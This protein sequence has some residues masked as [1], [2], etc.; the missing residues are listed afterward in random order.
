MEIDLE[1]NFDTEFTPPAPD[2]RMPT[3]EVEMESAS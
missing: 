1:M 3:V 2:G